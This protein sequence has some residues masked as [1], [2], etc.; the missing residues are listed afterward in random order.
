MDKNELEHKKFHTEMELLQEEAKP[1][2]DAAFK[3]YAKA[4]THVMIVGS[5]M[6][7]FMATGTIVAEF[8]IADPL[9]R[10]IVFTGSLMGTLNQFFELLRQHRDFSKAK[11]GHKEFMNLDLSYE[12]EHK[13]EAVQQA[14]AKLKN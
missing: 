4:H 8:M 1:K 13:E 9:V 12:G 10:A 3:S 2:I 14:E 7:V 11:K 5:L 6:L